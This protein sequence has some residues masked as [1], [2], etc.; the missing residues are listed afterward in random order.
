MAMARPVAFSGEGVA[1]R[2][3]EESGAGVAVPPGDARALSEALRRLAADHDRR[4]RQG[5]AGRVTI[6]ERFNRTTVAAKI[7]ASLRRAA[8]R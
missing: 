3:V 6:L 2:L 5:A 1:S 7:E 4:Q 8:G